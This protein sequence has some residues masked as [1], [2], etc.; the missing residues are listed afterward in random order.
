MASRSLYRGTFRPWVATIGTLTGLVLSAPAALASS[1][2]EAPNIAMN[3]SVDATDLYMF[4]S[5]ETRA[6]RPS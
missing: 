5:Y 3:P 2:R 6:A 1:H 4:R